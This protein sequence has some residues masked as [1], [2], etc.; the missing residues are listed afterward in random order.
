MRRI[1]VERARHKSS[2]KRG[3]GWQ[4]VNLDEV[5]LAS[6]TDSDLL[7]L[8]D[9]TL[10]EYAAKDPLGAEL[11]KLRF[12]AGI[13]NHEAAALLGVP[14]RTAKRTWAFARAWLYSEIQK[15]A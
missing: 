1:L 3:G 13:P 11:I 9:E 2:Q 10:A 14:E 5:D 15:R 12:F 7:L 4:R 8:L 6:D